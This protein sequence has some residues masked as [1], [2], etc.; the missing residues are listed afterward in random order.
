MQRLAFTFASQ[1]P[2]LT[3]PA[4][5]RQAQAFSFTRA[6]RKVVLTRDVSNLGFAGETCFVKPGHALNILVPKR[7]AMFFSDPAAQTFLSKIDVSHFLC[8]H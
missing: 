2:T 6:V 1:Q 3:S 8:S 4:L 7:Q 5:L